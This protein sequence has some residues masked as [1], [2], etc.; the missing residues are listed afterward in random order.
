MKVLFLDFN[1]VLDSDEYFDMVDPNNLKRL[2][3][4]VDLTGASVVITSSIKN[5]YYYLGEH[6]SKFKYVVGVLINNGINVIG[7]TEKCETREEEIRKYLIEHPEV[8]NYCIIDDEY[9]MLGMEN[10]FV[11]LPG[12]NEEQHG[13]TDEYVTKAIEILGPTKKYNQEIKN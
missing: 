12:P 6:N 1:G 11:K 5:G 9:E 2:K 13:L 7:W 8:D 3:Y 4:I 10:K